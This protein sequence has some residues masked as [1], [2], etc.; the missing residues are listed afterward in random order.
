MPEVVAHRDSLGQ[1]SLSPIARGRPGDLAD[2]E[3]MGQAHAV[4]VALGREEYLRLV[5]Q[6]AERLGVDDPVAVALETG[7]EGG[8]GA[9][10]RSRP[11]DS[12]ERTAKSDNVSRSIRSVRSRG[13]ST[14]AMVPATSDAAQLPPKIR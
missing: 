2:I 3:G 9:S 5:L 8:S 13:V 10:V 1:V 14:R 12:A 11:L 6:A 7:A 4:V